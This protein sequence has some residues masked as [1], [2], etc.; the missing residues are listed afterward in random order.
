[1][2][3][4]TLSFLVTLGACQDYNFSDGPQIDHTPVGYQPEDESVTDVLRQRDP[5]DQVDVLWVIDNSCSMQ[6]DQDELTAAFPEFMNFFIGLSDLDYH[7]G[8]VSTDMY[9]SGEGMGQLREADGYRW[10][11]RN[12]P[13]PIPYFDIMA[14]MGT[15]G[16]GD[17]MG[18]AGAY[19]ALETQRE[20][21]NAGFIRDDAFL[22]V[23]VISDEDDSSDMDGVDSD[24]FI[25]FMDN[26]KRE[27]GMVSYSTIV[28]P[29]PD[30]CTSADA[31]YGYEAVQKSIGGVF[32][33]ICDNQWDRLLEE[34]AMAAAGM[35]QE[36][37]LTR[38][39]IVDTL[40]V[41][42]HES[43]V[44]SDFDLDRDYVYDAERNSIRFLDY[45]PQ[46]Y[47][48]VIVSYDVE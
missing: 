48:E 38:Q 39:P 24:L 1:M 22:S 8:V 21:V 33:S 46:P 35:K 16:S 32:W 40:K 28:G 31:G 27:P 11:D 13:D 3:I 17:E 43:G 42:V 29:T 4:A 2:R 14:N 18:R 19:H 37:Y 23:V 9:D 36:F 7:I 44:I 20:D 47:A 41:E 10:I 5:V 26:F 15:N 25:D 30:G 34:L 45:V 12:V 6:D